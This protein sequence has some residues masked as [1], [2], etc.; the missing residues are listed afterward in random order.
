MEI[1]ETL[2]KIKDNRFHIK[3]IKHIGPATKFVYAI[4]DH[5]DKLIAICDDDQIYD[6]LWLINL[7]SKSS[8]YNYDVAVGLSG[9]IPKSDYVD[10]NNDVY[11]D[12][13]G[14]VLGYKNKIILK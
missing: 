10:K 1:H 12:K 2:L 8:E 5:S 11:I 13:N 4:E 9:F 14:T 7:V 3:R 6:K